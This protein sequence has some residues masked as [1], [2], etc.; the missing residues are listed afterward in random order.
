[1][2]GFHYVYISREKS[3]HEDRSS[4]FY[5]SHTNTEMLE[6][7]MKEKKD[8]EKQ[9]AH[10][11]SLLQNQIHAKNKEIQRLEDK[12]E[13]IVSGPCRLMGWKYGSEPGITVVVNNHL[14]TTTMG[15]RTISA[16]NPL[17]FTKSCLLSIIS[18]I[19]SDKY[20]MII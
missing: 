4:N 19:F 10:K 2:P 11:L 6:T 8:L 15:P 18:S 12:L 14:P 5:S 7:I 20:D 3:S 1:M 9:S 17:Y 13:D 16:K